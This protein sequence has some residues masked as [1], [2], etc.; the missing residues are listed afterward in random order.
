MNF[1]IKNCNVLVKGLKDKKN[2]FYLWTLSTP[3]SFFEKKLG[4]KL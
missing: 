3:A 1:I 2:I 4:K